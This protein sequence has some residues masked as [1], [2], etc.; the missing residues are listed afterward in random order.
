MA[1]ELSFLVLPFVLHR[2]T[3]ESLP[4]NITTSLSTW[5]AEHPIVRSRL[6]ERAAMLRSFTRD[7]LV[8]GGS[9]DLLILDQGGIRPNADM[10][11]RVTTCLKST[12]DEVRD[13]AKRAEVL[14]R[15]FERA[16][17]AETVMSLLGVRP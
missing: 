10:K 9:H 8:F 7:A 16:G 2:E 17:G 13:C 6:G 1:I 14:G 3:R 5:L 15:W 4:R 11:K 12:S